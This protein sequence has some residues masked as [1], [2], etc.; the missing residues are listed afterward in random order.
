MAMTMLEASTVLQVQFEQADANFVDSGP[1]RR[2][3]EPL[4]PGPTASGAAKF[5]NYA[6]E[7][8]GSAGSYAG[9]LFGTV[10]LP[11]LSP[12]TLEAF[13]FMPAAQPGSALRYIFDVGGSL[14][15]CPM[16]SIE[17]T[18]GRLRCGAGSSYI[19]SDAAIPTGRWVHVEVARDTLGVTR[20][21]VDGVTQTQSAAT[22]A[23][24]SGSGAPNAIIG[25]QQGNSGTS[26][27]G[28]IDQLRYVV[29]LGLHDGDFS[30]PSAAF[31]ECPRPIAA[32]L[33]GQ[34]RTAATGSIASAAPKVIP[35]QELV[36]DLY[37][38]G[39]G[40]INDV[41]NV[42]GTPDYPIRRKVWLMRDRD[43]VVIRETW[44]DA[45][46][47]AYSFDFVDERERYSVLTFDHERNF[48]AVIADN[49]KP[50]LI[51]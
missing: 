8:A 30:P 42:K 43:G 32:V 20:I 6:Y 46:T 22:L 47:G 37:Y 33:A 3:S 28:R 50:D 27:M 40:R 13:I 34:R 14:S 39:R 41:V 45:V 12:W 21:F 48:R 9:L 25:S 19:Y 38:G 26:F 36:R 35:M 49:L 31:D 10:P 29:G 51:A 24:M 15:T 17:G 4:S 23:S 1:G 44:S 5:G 16:L 18:T 7:Y 11:L 2:R